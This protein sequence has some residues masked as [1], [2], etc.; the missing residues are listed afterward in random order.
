[1]LEFFSGSDMYAIYDISRNVAA[2]NWPWPRRGEGRTAAY[3]E[4]AANLGVSPGSRWN[5]GTCG[6]EDCPVSLH[7]HKYSILLIPSPRVLA[8]IYDLIIAHPILI[9]LMRIKINNKKVLGLSGV[10]LE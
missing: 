8:F 10:Q 4:L 5:R 3:D 9:W 1:M 6:A 2:G 7:E